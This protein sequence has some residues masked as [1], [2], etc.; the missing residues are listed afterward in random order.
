MSNQFSIA[1]KSAKVYNQYI[2][3]AGTKIIVSAFYFET[4]RSRLFIKNCKLIYTKYS[5]YLYL[6]D[7]I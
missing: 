1:F 6:F 7:F 2:Q 4:E 5:N 3:K